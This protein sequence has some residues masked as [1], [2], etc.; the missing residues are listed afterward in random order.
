M[1]SVSKSC[2]VCRTALHSCTI[3]SRLSSLVQEESAIKAAPLIID[4]KRSS[5]D[6]LDRTSLYVSG[7]MIIF[8]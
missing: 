5:N 6:G 7:S 2:K 1:Y 8:C 4:S 3:R